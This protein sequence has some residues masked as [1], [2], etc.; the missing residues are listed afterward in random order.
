[1]F[2]F[3]ILF[4]KKLKEKQVKSSRPPTKPTRSRS[5]NPKSYPRTPK[6]S[7]NTQSVRNSITTATTINS[8]INSHKST[9]ATATR[10]VKSFSMSSKANMPASAS[11]LRVHV[12]R[13]RPNQDLNHELDKY[14][15]EH[16]LKAAF[17]MTCVGSLTRATLRMAYSGAETNEVRHFD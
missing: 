7:S 3:F 17:V 16:D 8:T 12:I 14:V 1:M 6:P 11:N 9:T 13:L 2:C 4:W 10:R 5:E 15:K